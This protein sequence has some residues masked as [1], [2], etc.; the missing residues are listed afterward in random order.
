MWPAGPLGVRLLVTGGTRRAG[1]DAPPPA[2][3]WAPRSKAALLATRRVPPPAWGPGSALQAVGILCPDSNHLLGE[4]R[5]QG[6]PQV[7]KTHREPGPARAG[8]QGPR[9]P[10]PCN[11]SAFRE[12]E[13][14]RPGLRVW[15][16]T[17]GAQE[18]QAQREAGPPPTGSP[19]THGSAFGH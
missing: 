12:K 15:P 16:Q 19:Q 10:I 3:C 14:A 8:G 1:G 11:P 2:S 17:Q 9:S 6:C 18:E 7:P 13:T 5:P 4:H